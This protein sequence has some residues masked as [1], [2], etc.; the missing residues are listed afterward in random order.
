VFM[1]ANISSRTKFLRCLRTASAVLSLISIGCLFRVQE[2]LYGPDYGLSRPFGV[3]ALV[4]LLVPAGVEWT[5]DAFIDREVFPLADKLF[6]VLPWVYSSVLVGAASFGVFFFQRGLTSESQ[7]ALFS[8]A[9]FAW[10]CPHEFPQLRAVIGVV[11]G[12]ICGA[13]WWVSSN[14]AYLD[15][16]IMSIATPFIRLD[17]R[18]TPAKSDEAR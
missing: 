9:Y 14:H 6:T 3:G 17:F 11:I 8:G 13:I 16:G 7:Q 15:L 1:A 2:L 12:A 10:L 18:D 5:A 4:L